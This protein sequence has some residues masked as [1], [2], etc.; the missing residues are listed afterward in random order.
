MTYTYEMKI[1]QDD[2]PVQAAYL[3]WQAESDP[4]GYLRAGDLAAYLLRIHGVTYR[5][6]RY[7]SSDCRAMYR[8]YLEFKDESHALEFVLTV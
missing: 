5:S 2:H 8:W 1:G 6:E 7:N 3:R 4:S